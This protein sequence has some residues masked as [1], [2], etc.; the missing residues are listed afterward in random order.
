MRSRLFIWSL[1]PLLLLISVPLTFSFAQ[2]DQNPFGDPSSTDPFADDSPAVAGKDRQAAPPE[3]EQ[4]K[5]FRSQIQ[6]IEQKYTEM[7]L[8]E[9]ALTES[10]GKVLKERKLNR[11]RNADGE[12][13]DNIKETVEQLRRSR[14]QIAELA[15]MNELLKKRIGA[16]ESETSEHKLRAQE[17]VANRNEMHQALFESLLLS[18]NRT[19]QQMALEHLFAC[20]D[21]YEAAKVPINIYSPKLL[22]Q[23]SQLTS[24]DSEE[25]KRLA[26]RCLFGFK[27][28]Y[29]IA[30]GI[31]FGPLWRPL[32]HSKANLNTQRIHQMLDHVCDFVFEEEPL[33]DLVDMLKNQFAVGF[34]LGEGVDEEMLIT[35]DATNRSLFLNLS[36]MLEK[37]KL[38][39]VISNDEVVILKETDPALKVLATYNTA[40]LSSL[41]QIETEK[42]M[43]LLKKSFESDPVELTLIGENLFTAKA[44]A[45]HQRKIQKTLGNLAPPAKWYSK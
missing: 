25:V 19:H 16:L 44:S 10:L 38:G 36:G 37:H 12:L 35:Y 31:Q 18:E 33:A 7:V 13:D 4:L 24:S 20:G 9:S 27:P 34:R 39:F 17:A 15:Q 3:S 42:A 21:K 26:S 6:E 29:A 2:E 23:V 28:D 30:A 1:L 22:K 40:G 14:N 41:A 43:Q 32:E 8:R 5:A 45:V 11:L